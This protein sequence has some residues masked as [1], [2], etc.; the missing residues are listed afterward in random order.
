MAIITEW[1][2]DYLRTKQIESGSGG[3]TFNKASE[4]ACSIYNKGF[5]N[6]RVS[7]D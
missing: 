1:L 6:T 3:G 7:F 4:T 5:E 2:I